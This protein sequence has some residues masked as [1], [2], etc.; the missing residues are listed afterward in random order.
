MICGQC[1]AVMGLEIFTD[2][3]KYE[4]GKGL[5]FAAS[6][7]SAMLVPVFILF[8]SH[9]NKKKDRDQHSPEAVAKRRLG[10]EEIGDDHPDFRFW[11]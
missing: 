8:I 7:L 11:L 5:G 1:F 3:P 6:A 4:R 9:L 2:A 10:I